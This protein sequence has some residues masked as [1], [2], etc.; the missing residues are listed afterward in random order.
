MQK[1]VFFSDSECH[2]PGHL[3]S[4]YLAQVQ[5]PIVI[6]G[7]NITVRPDSYILAC[8]FHKH[9]DRTCPLLRI[10][11]FNF[12]PVLELVPSFGEEPF[13]KWEF[14]LWILKITYNKVIFLAYSCFPSSHDWRVLLGHSST[15]RILFE[16]DFKL[17]FFLIEL[18][19]Q[20]YRNYIRN[21]GRRLKRRCV[22]IAS[23]W[24]EKGLS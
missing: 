13:F 3:S 15:S 1:T 16:R 6:N 21:F 11:P 2:D 9:G 24:P 4:H 17:F 8:T 5:F 20:R 22:E 7:W 19:H 23:F 14:R 18:F 12:A 10:H